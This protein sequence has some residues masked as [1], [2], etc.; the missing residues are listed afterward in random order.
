M[1]T[2]GAGR[3]RTTPILVLHPT[4]LAVPYIGD[5]IRTRHCVKGLKLAQLQASDGK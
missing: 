3:I 2:K 4:V 1:G 5:E